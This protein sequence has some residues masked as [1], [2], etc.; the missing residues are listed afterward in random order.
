MIKHLSADHEIILFAVNDSEVSE[1]QTEQLKPYCKFIYWEKISKLNSY[2]NL[3]KN[4]LGYLP[5]SVAYFLRETVC[6]RIQDIISEHQPDHIFCHL[7]RMSEYVKDVNHIPK[8]LDYM[9]TFSIGMGRMKSTAGWFMQS[10]ITTEHKRLLRYEEQIFD[11]FDNKIIISEQDR[12]HIPHKNNQEIK[13]VP[14]GVDFDFFYPQ[15]HQKKYD[16]LFAGNMNYPPNIESVMFIA[17]EI[18]PLLRK[19]LPEVKLIIAGATPAKEILQLQ[20]PYIEV[21]GWVDDIRTS[22]YESHIM[23][24]PMLISIGL[25]NK[26]LQAMAMKIPCVVS[27]LANNAIHAT[28]QKEVLIAN[29]PEE[30]V[31]HILYLLQNKK[32]ATELAENAYQFAK[33]NYDWKSIVAQLSVMMTKHQ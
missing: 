16:L 31:K 20:S 11:C 9:D 14:N 25:Q 28:H 2:L 1:E 13:V 3:A 8:T 12:T 10:I 33:A 17:N 22:F 4:F 21:T 26:I 29:T 32:E 7:I 23:L 15:Q 6:Y 19:Q 18:L 5:F 30:Y 24:A 27:S